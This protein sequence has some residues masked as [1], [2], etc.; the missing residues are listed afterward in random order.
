M[1]KISNAIGTWPTPEKP[2]MVEIPVSLLKEFE[3]DARIVIRHPWIIGIPVLDALIKPELNKKI[4]TS[5]FEVI[6]IPKVDMR[7]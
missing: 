3:H 6:I 2:L 5:G 4:D 1:P 7:Y